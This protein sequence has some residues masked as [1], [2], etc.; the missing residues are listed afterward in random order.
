MRF[1]LLTFI[2]SSCLYSAEIKGQDSKS[3]FDSQPWAKADLLFH[4][5][6]RWKGS[7]GA[8]SIDLGGE[9]I[10]W[11]FGDTYIAY[12]GPYERTRACVEMIRNSIAIQN[13]Y[14]PSN[15]NI[16]FFWHTD[17]SLPASFFPEADTTWLWP[18][19]GIRLEN[20]LLIFFAKMHGIETGMGFE[21]CGQS[22]K[23]IENPDDNP[24]KWCIREIP[25]PYIRDSVLIGSALEVYD[26]FLYA[27]CCREPGNHDMFLARW[28]VDSARMGYLLNP[29]WWCGDKNGWIQHSDMI[30]S[31]EIIIKDG[32]TE[33][34][35]WF[36]SSLN[37]FYQVQT[38][39]FGQA[40]LVFR[41]A[42]QLTGPWCEPK[43]I[44]DPPENKIPRIK[45]Y[46]AKAHPHMHGA[47]IVL[48]Y[49]TNAP[50][51]LIVADTC[52]YYP[53]FVRANNIR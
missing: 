19:D 9:R 5:D 50:E 45:I 18:L 33:F 17:D 31:P 21:V 10:L 46:A 13:G 49:A 22:V 30:H 42:P 1:I 27:F 43:V 15:A 2:F 52:L 34:S 8:Y 35:F 25:L 37:L 36:D 24:D 48:T 6:F 14:D 3:G 20:K 39:G 32:A 51:S 16:R 26:G 23:M 40:K 53:R 7:D 41:Q 38:I 47:D 4:T 28:S 44:Y 29:E 12:K 11:L